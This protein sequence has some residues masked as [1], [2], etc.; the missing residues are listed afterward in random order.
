MSVLQRISFCLVK[1]LRTSFEKKKNVSKS[2]VGK[3][4]R[5]RKEGQRSQGSGIYA[6]VPSITIQ[7]NRSRNVRAGTLYLWEL[8]QG[9]CCFHL[10][11]KPPIKLSKEAVV[12]RPRS[13]NRAITS[14][15]LITRH[16]S[17]SHVIGGSKCG[18]ITS[19]LKTI[20]ALWYR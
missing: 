5:R 18:L 3:L 16:S 6:Q 17:F 10:L 19:A 1:A 13:N 4:V 8:G 2:C 15:R 14:Q 20:T 9:S 11:R 7:S 12:L